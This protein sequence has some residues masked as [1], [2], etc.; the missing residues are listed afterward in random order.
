MAS[1]NTIANKVFKV[2]S[3]N[4]VFFFRYHS[5]A[6]FFEGEEE[7]ETEK[8]VFEKNKIFIWAKPNDYKVVIT[9]HNIRY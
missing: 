9:T 1:N 3:L 7:D 4:S 2:L 8:K 5:L 6:F